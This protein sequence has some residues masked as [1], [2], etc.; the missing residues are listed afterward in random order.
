MSSF[1][2]DTFAGRIVLALTFF[3]ALHLAKFLG[4]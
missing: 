2:I 3:A 4:A 1:I